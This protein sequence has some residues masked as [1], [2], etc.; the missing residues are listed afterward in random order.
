MEKMRLDDVGIRN[1]QVWQIGKDEVG[2]TMEREEQWSNKNSGE[3]IKLKD[4][5]Y[6]KSTV[7]S[8]GRMPKKGGW[9]VPHLCQHQQE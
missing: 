2:A 5:V 7:S 9:I 6:F 4:F 3:I 1:D 8:N